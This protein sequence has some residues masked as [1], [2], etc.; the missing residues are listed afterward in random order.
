ME[1]NDLKELKYAQELLEKPG[2]IIKVANY[3]G[4]PVEFVFEKVDSKLINKATKKALE[5]S[6]EIAVSSLDEKS[7]K[8][9]GTHKFL[10]ALS[11]GVGGFFG[12]A[13]LPLELPVTTT[14]MLRSIAQIAKH[15]GHDIKSREVQLECLEIFSLGSSKT[16]SD[17][18]AESAY[19]AARGALAY[20]MKAAVNAVRGMSEKAIQ[21]ALSRGQMP[22]LV[23]FINTIASRF[24]VTVS[25][26][27]VA[28]SVPFI[29]AA[30]GAALNTLF[31]EHFQNMAEGHF[32]VRKLEKKYGEEYVREV[33]LKLL[34]K[35]I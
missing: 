30:G 32:I 29:G 33:Y 15:H 2:F 11:G 12:M 14:I 1:A 24:G 26:K 9:N 18:G 21:E 31:T 5:K 4:K 19:F 20:E 34:N 13:A 16:A 28:Q 10:T 3:F 8:S 6:L 23:K 27:I 25:E 22:V 7:E 35:N 17:D